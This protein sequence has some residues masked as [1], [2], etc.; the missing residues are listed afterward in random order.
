MSIQKT[1][2]KYKK[3]TRT[4]THTQKQ[5]KTKQNELKIGL[6]K[7]GGGGRGV[8]GQGNVIQ[9]LMTF[10]SAREKRITQLL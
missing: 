9:N 1:T 10:S 2:Q 3:T 4:H 8:K 5:N 7:L 6:G